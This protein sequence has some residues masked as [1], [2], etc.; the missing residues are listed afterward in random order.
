MGRTFFLSPPVADLQDMQGV[1][2]AAEISLA[3]IVEKE[4]LEAIR[5]TSPLKAPGPEGLPSCVLPAT[6]DII[7]GHLTS[8]FDQSLRIGECSADVRSSITVVIRKPGKDDATPSISSN[9]F[10]KHDSQDYG[11]CPGP[12]AELPRGNAPCPSKHSSQGSRTEV[13]RARDPYDHRKSLQS[14]EQ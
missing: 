13:N 6:A 7:A 8:I 9:S 2:N 5:S 11:C 3:P 14:V 4:T 12:R 10:A 1:Q